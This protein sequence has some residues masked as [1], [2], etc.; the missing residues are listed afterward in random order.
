MYGDYERARVSYRVRGEDGN[1]ISINET[2]DLSAV[3]VCIQQ[4]DDKGRLATISLNEKQFK[5]LMDLEN[6]FRFD[7]KK[8]AN[9]TANESAEPEGGAG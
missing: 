6:R 9:E 4:N 7:K 5:A 1:D 2:P 8:L 3:V